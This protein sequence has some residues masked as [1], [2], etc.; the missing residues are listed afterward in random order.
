MRKLLSKAA[1]A[2][3]VLALSAAGTVIGVTGTA[4][5]SSGAFGVAAYD[6]GWG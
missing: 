1:V 6:T 2:G 3:C 4:T 5:V